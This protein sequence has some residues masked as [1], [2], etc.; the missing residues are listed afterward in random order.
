[1]D[2]GQTTAFAFQLCRFLAVLTESSM[3]FYAEGWLV[4][5]Y[6]IPVTPLVLGHPSTTPIALRYQGRWV[7]AEGSVG[8]KEGQAAPGPAVGQHALEPATLG[9]LQQPPQ[10]WQDPGHVEPSHPDQEFLGLADGNLD[11]E[12]SIPVSWIQ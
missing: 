7:P 5:P 3:I 9:H 6:A 8:G 4:H 1:M 11:P 10:R 12:T 2:G